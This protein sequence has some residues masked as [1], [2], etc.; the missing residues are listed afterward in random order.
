MSVN[1][2]FTAASGVTA[3][4]ACVIAAIGLLHELL[5]GLPPEVLIHELEGWVATVGYHLALILL[6]AG[7]VSYL[8]NKKQKNADSP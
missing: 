2:L 6:A 7:I 8:A 4:V 1:K 5:S 3:G